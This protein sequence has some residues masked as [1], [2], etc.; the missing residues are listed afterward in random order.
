MINQFDPH[1]AVGVSTYSENEDEDNEG[2]L[3]GMDSFSAPK[4]EQDLR[5]Y[6]GQR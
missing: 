6:L 2:S 4:F 1:G 3:T 5:A